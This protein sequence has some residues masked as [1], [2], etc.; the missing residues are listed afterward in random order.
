MSH[1]TDET[2]RGEIVFK[3]LV[4]YNLVEAVAHIL[5]YVNPNCDNGFA[6]KFSAASGYTEIVKLLLAHPEIEVH[7]IALE[8]ASARGHLETVSYLI[9]DPRFVNKDGA[10]AQAAEYGFADIVRLLLTSENVNPGF[11]NNHAIMMA[12]RNNHLD[13]VRQ[14]FMDPRVNPSV[15]D[16]CV[17]GWAASEGH[18]DIVEALLADR[19]VNP[20]ANHNYAIRMASFYGHTEVVRMLLTDP[21]VDPSADRQYALNHASIRGHVDV[22]K[23]LYARKLTLNEKISALKAASK[24]HCEDTVRLWLGYLGSEVT[25]N[26]YLNMKH[27]L[28]PTI[29][30]LWKDHVSR[31]GKFETQEHILRG[32][33]HMM[34]R[35]HK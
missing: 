22:V 27:F 26:L 3:Y 33:L 15:D 25:A 5:T 9:A 21:R 12:V 13:V 6:L 34:S 16:N 19:R 8:S 20:A 11:G 31:C 28:N 17:I 30:K 24:N 14:L 32:K 2:I 7:D 18:V 4:E 10:L 35:M 23:L 29:N 1:T